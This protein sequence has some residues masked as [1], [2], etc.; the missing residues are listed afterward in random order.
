MFVEGNPAPTF[1][2]FWTKNDK[3]LLEGGRYKFMSD[4][5]NSN[6]VALVINNTDH[7]DDDQYRLVIE[8]CHGRDEA[9]F[10]LMITGE[11]EASICY[12]WTLYRGIFAKIWDCPS[13]T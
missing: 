11:N 4:G 13:Y 5:D 10:N 9:V 2:F 3:E 12:R 7:Q 6:M 1:K 8:N